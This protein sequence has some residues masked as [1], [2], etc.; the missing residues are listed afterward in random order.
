MKQ[1]DAEL[2]DVFKLYEAGKTYNNR[3]DYYSIVNSNEQM[4]YGDQ[5]EGVKSN[6]LPTPSINILKPYVSYTTAFLTSTPL[7]I[8]Y[9]V[10][11]I[12]TDTEDETEQSKLDAINKLNKLTAAQ[13]ENNKIDDLLKDVI[14][15]GNVTGDMA[16]YVYWDPNIETGNDIKGD[17]VTEIV[18]G[19]NVMF[20]NPNSKVVN[21]RG[22][23][24]QPYI[25]IIGR[26]MVSI[27]KERARA[28]GMPQE[29]IDKIVADQDFNETAGERGK[30]E[31]D[32]QDETKK[33]TYVI[34]FYYVN[35]TKTVHFKEATSSAYI[36]KDIDTKMAI[37][38]IAWENWERRKNSYHGQAS[39]TNYK[40]NQR[41]INKQLALV[42]AHYMQLAV[43]KVIYLKNYL[44]GWNNQVGGA[45]GVDG[46]D[47]DVAKY[48][49]G[50][51]MPAGVMDTV[52][53]TINE[54]NKVLGTNDAVTGNINPENKGAIVQVLEQSAIPLLNQKTAIY[55]FVEQLAEIWFEFIK[56][57]YGDIERK[58]TIVEDDK[59][60]VIKFNPSIF[61]DMLVRPK[62]DVGPSTLYNENNTVATLDNLYTAQIINAVQYL[63]RMPEGRIPMK[64]ELIAE[65]EKSLGI[66]SADEEM[67]KRAEYE[68]M[69]QYVDA[70]QPEIQ[71][72]LER[73]PDAEREQ[74]IRDM[75]AQD[76][77][78]PQPQA[79][80][81]ELDAN[82]GGV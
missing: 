9:S 27:L 74:T 44:N 51:N 70:L 4:V 79:Q 16:S 8:N 60:K 21:K 25:L 12:E 81:N 52:T 64:K 78:N 47:L 72:E 22:R 31:I 49:Q 48:M 14:N 19:V 23:A 50:V 63:K 82:L 68:M 43:P 13:W 54:T 38:P 29:E 3:L 30:I 67:N 80:M 41:Y 57:K 37:Y 61:K 26:E 34:K 35:E 71:A 39:V 46:N 40:Q 58:A 77:S 28:N 33:A 15:D 6:G 56:T 75:M 24:Y 32:E 10:E 65:V 20:G 53:T 36:R 17:Y 18:D 7:K 42:M 69:A 62:I 11:N 5:W 59:T 1:N 66:I 76:T 45:I 55:N 2:T 73:L